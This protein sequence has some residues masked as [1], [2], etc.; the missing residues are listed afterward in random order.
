M[1]ILELNE[2]NLDKNSLLKL[3]FLQR[4]IKKFKNDLIKA[5]TLIGKKKFF[6]SGNELKNIKFQRSVY[7]VKDIKK[8][9]KFTTKN[10]KRIRPGYSWSVDKWSKLLGKTSKRNLDR[11]SRITKRDIKYQN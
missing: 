11:G 4:E 5:W 2:I 6:R 1:I 7:V 10:I 3:N 9:E 8:G